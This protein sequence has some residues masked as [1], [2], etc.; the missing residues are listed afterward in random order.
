[1]PCHG[2]LSSPHAQFVEVKGPSDR[3]SSKQLL[4]LSRLVEW[5][6]DRE[7]ADM[8]HSWRLGVSRLGRSSLGPLIVAMVCFSS[9]S[10]IHTPSGHSIT[11]LGPSLP[12]AGSYVAQFTT[13]QPT[14][15]TCVV[16]ALLCLCSSSGS[17]C[18][19]GASQVPTSLTCVRVHT[20]K[21]YYYCVCAHIIW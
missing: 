11:A 8:L 13:S 10:P 7:F 9:F 12:Q 17:T 1:M 3:L 4:W 18:V 16:V 21:L 20:Y 14:T 19:Q 5:G 6:C 2:L 15:D